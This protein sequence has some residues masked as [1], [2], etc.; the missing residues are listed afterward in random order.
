MFG[1]QGSTGVDFFAKSNLLSV[2]LILKFDIGSGNSIASL[3]F[4]FN[5]EY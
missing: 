2:L 5:K 4:Y 1:V 3:N